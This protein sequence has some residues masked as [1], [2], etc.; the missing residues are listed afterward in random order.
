MKLKKIIPEKTEENEVNMSADQ[1]ESSDV[2]N[3][4]RKIFKLP[5]YY[6]FIQDV[7]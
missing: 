5:V 4:K 6:K 7:P 3:W 1:N 2:R